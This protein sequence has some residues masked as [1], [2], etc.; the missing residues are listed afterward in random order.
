MFNVWYASGNS[1]L[2]FLARGPSRV[3][4]KNN[5]I[6]NLIFAHQDPFFSNQFKPS[7]QMS[8]R[9]AILYILRAVAI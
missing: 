3:L 6:Q 9:I 7:F 1:K 2:S 4:E 5:K 8:L